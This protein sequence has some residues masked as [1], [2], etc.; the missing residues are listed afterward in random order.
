MAH[1][2]QWL[3]RADVLC[4]TQRHGRVGVLSQRLH[5]GL[6]AYVTQRQREVN[7]PCET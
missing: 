4:E 5:G 2:T 1:G 3:R 6:V 7:V